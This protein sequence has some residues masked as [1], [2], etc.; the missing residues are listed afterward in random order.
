MKRIALVSVIVL[1]GLAS[2]ENTENNKGEVVAQVYEAYLYKSDLEAVTY[3]GMTKYDSMIRVNAFVN[4]WVRKQILLN[5]AKRNLDLKKLDFSKQ[6]DD[7]LNS[8]ITFTYETEIINQ[9]L[10]TVVS[11]SEIERYY[12]EHKYDFELHHNIVKTAFVAIPSDFNPQVIKMFSKVMSRTDTLLID[13]LSAMVERHA[14]MNYLDVDNWIA[15]DDILNRV[16]IEV[17]N[18]EAFLKKNKFVSFEHESMVYL[19]RFCDYLV[20]ESTSPIE[21]VR[22]R[23]RS[24]ILNKRR[25]EM[26]RKM[27]D[28]LYEKAVREKAIKI[29]NN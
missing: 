2:C 7:Y 9:N 1:L 16:P 10:D 17:Y 18:Q 29:Y 4:T 23:I 19:V 21:I 28:D 27:N 14:V 22:N 11:D 5:Q 20:K 13:S 26:L 15:F 12:D 24:I 8:L 6:L 25:N 3:N